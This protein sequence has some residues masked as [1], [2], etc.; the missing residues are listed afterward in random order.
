[1]VHLEMK[2][3]LIVS[4]YF[5][6]Y[7]AIGSKRYGKM[8]KYFKEYGYDPYVITTRHDRHGYLDVGM[9]LEVPLDK[10]KIFKIGHVK[11]N[12]VVKRALGKWIVRILETA[13]VDSRTISAWSFG[14]YEKVKKELDIS[15]LGKIDI[16]VGTFPPM[17]NL[18]VA[19]YLSKRLNCPYVVDIRDLISDYQYAAEGHRRCESLDRIIEKRV[20]K[21][22]G[23]I[24]AVTSGFRDTLKRRFPGKLT[25][26]VFNGWDSTVDAG[27][28]V[29]SNEKYLYYAGSLY[30]HR[31]ESFALLVKCL[32]KINIERKEKF[33]LIV[34]SVGPKVLDM[35]I[36]EMIRRERLQ[37]YVF[38]YGSAPE[39]IVRREQSGAYINVVF[40]TLH[41]DDSA[42]MS[43]VPAKLY[44]MLQGRAAILVIA[45]KN[46]D[47]S[48]ILQYT[49]KGIAS[50][51]EK[52]I[53][54]FI[55]AGHDKYVGNGNIAYFS[56]KKQAERLCEFMD[57]VLRKE[58]P[59]IIG[60]ASDKA[61]VYTNFKGTNETGNTD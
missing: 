23:G 59:V 20:L 11:D 18:F 16:I 29:L 3:V 51:S 38:L 21:D 60:N 34:R 10:E 31:L 6:P 47:A 1:M 44:E 55:V 5:P 36:K 45:P 61:G 24:V 25:R 48:K 30:E 58:K 19:R 9:D 28:E 35:R 53:E 26:V 14:W 57:Y 15:A 56:R 8:C 39:E 27:S 43:T 13:K 54:D 42:L 12:F 17:Q 49:N 32:R 37:E 41:E 40:H 33:K 22:A 52:E 2:K 7:N 50:I 46:T 4:Y